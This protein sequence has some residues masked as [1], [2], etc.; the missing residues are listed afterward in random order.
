MQINAGLQISL[1]AVSLTAFC[2]ATEL[3]MFRIP[4]VGVQQSIR[5]LDER[6]NCHLVHLSQT[7]SR[8]QHC[9]DLLGFPAAEMNRRER[10]AAAGHP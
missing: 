7:L 2:A 4:H 5:S 3:L 6:R 9:T 1:R 10:A 8:L